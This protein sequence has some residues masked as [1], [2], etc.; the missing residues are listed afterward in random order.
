MLGGHFKYVSLFGQRVFPASYLWSLAHG[1]R[2][3]CSEYILGFRGGAFTPLSDLTTEPLYIIALCSN[4]PL[5]EKVDMSVLI[6]S[7]R[8][9]LVQRDEQA[10]RRETELL[11]GASHIN[12][13]Q[14]ENENLLKELHRVR[15]AYERI[16]PEYDKVRS[17]LNRVTEAYHQAI[18]HSKNLEESRA[19]AAHHIQKVEGEYLAAVG[20]LG[21]VENELRRV[22]REFARL[23]IAHRAGKDR[24][25]AGKEDTEH[26]PLE[27]SGAH[28]KNH[29]GP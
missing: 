17:E 7:D 18:D 21:S 24:P 29:D 16:E 23:E 2:H 13:L 3:R 15:A 26:E 11:A 19:E 10:S 12:A 6:D 8:R 25:E 14:K 4:R 28:G 1:P 22:S 5:D 27:T 9:A 20:Q